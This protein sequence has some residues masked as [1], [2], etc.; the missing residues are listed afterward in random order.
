LKAKEQEQ[1][2]A[3]D[4]AGQEGGTPGSASTAPPSS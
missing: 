4:L 1:K 3:S 2:E